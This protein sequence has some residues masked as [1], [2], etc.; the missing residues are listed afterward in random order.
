MTD[1]GM[2][3]IYQAYGKFVE[4]FQP[5]KPVRERLEYIIKA[6]QSALAETKG[7]EGAEAAREAI[8]SAAVRAMQELRDIDAALKAA[9]EAGMEAEKPIRAAGEG[10][11]T[12]KAA[13]QD[14][15]MMDMSGIVNGIRGAADAMWDLATASWTVEPPT[16]M[17]AAHGGKA[18]RFLAGGGPVGTDVIPAMLSPGEVVINA[19][20][21]RNFASQLTAINAG[22]QPVYRSEGGSVTN[23]G[24]INVRIEGKD[25]ARLTPRGFW[26]QVRREA[27]RGTVKV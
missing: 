5:E 16:A 26:E 20:S 17:T 4:V 12:A 10:A 27:R 11:K 3:D 18:W 13:L 23:I 19:A 8:Q 14:V 2:K 7:K 25:A 1:Q 6:A 22:V 15:S 9:K 21:A 24:D